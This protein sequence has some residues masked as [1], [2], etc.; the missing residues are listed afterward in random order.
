MIRN[1]KKVPN[2]YENFF[3]IIIY[4]ISFEIN[5]IL[6]ILGIT[7]NILTTFSFKHTDINVWSAPD[8]DKLNDVF[9]ISTCSSNDDAPTRNAEA[10]YVRLEPEIED[11]KLKP[12]SVK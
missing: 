4:D 5:K 7:P 6:Y 12:Q 2:E 3:D 11:V 10:V 1:K 8:K 9:V